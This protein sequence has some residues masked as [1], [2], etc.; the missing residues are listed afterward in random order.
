MIIIY[1]EDIV[2][3]RNQLNDLILAASVGG[4]EVKRLS[5]KDA[6]LTGITQILEGL[7]LF[8]KTPVLVIEGLFSLPKSKN[9]DLLLDFMSKYAD[10]DIFLLEDKA[11]TSTVLKPF[12]K[13]KFHEHKPPAIIFSFLESLHPNGATKSL[14][15][16]ADLEAAHQPPELIF[17]MLVRQVR[18]L[19]QALEPNTLKAAPWQKS[20]LIA[21]ARLFSEE[22]LLKF[23]ANLY[24]IDKEL[25]TGVNPL[26]LSLHLFNLIA[27]L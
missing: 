18:L 6:D 15:L 20:R 1:G 16:L 22:G 26:D 11:L 17:A 2:S 10:R 4:K 3:A 14:K 25:K 8:G 12:A 13:A 7:T 19:I 9:K 21:Q 5:A 24:R 23:H 27:S